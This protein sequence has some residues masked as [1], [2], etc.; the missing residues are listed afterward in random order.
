MTDLSA[1][2]QKSI[3]GK[4]REFKAVPGAKTFFLKQI[5]GNTG[6]LVCERVQGGTGAISST[7]VHFG[8]QL[9]S[10]Q[11]NEQNKAVS[12]GS[13]T[14]Y[15]IVTRNIMGNPNEMEVPFAQ[16]NAGDFEVSYTGQVNLTAT[17]QKKFDPDGT[18]A[19]ALGAGNFI[20]YDTTTIA[21][22]VRSQWAFRNKAFVDPLLVV[23]PLIAPPTP[24]PCDAN[25]DG[26][27]GLADIQ[28]ILAARNTAVSPGD[29][30]DPDHDGLI[31]VNDARICT[32]RITRQYT[33]Y[34]D[35]PCV[36][37]GLSARVPDLP[38]CTL[39]NQPPAPVA[40]D[41]NLFS[42]YTETQPAGTIIP[43]SLNVVTNGS[44]SS[45][46]AAT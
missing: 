12:Y 9:V 7:S 37:S 1:A 25:S 26:F 14:G 19:A 29:P 23:Q 27:V 42:F 2:K 20:D 13:I 21:E 3:L 46:R 39:L 15:K 5:G 30:R 31:T 34:V 43:S 32:Q 35:P 11:A 44:L 4:D 38:A 45:V 33:L 28:A 18:C 40:V 36:P 6:K 24:I 10:L 22:G 17:P 41:I 16:L 8:C